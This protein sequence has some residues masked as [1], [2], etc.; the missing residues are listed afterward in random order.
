MVTQISRDMFMRIPYGY[1]S[2]V[3]TAAEYSSPAHPPYSDI[4]ELA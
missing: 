3:S 1:G 4:V 2:P